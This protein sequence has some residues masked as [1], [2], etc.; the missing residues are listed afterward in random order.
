MVF[1]ATPVVAERKSYCGNADDHVVVEV[2]E[3]QE[4]KSGEVETGTKGIGRGS[5]R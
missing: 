2:H 4:D 1:A 5:R 3:Q